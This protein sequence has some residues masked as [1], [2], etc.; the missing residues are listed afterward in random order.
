MRNRIRL[1]LRMLP[2]VMLSILPT[3]CSEAVL[4]Q[5]TPLV[6]DGSN[7]FMHDLIF[8]AAPFVLP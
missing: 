5:L 3:S 1:G 4:R 7:S 2:F 8:T 6:I